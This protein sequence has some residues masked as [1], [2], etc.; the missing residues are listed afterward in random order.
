MCVVPHSGPELG[1]PILAKDDVFLNILASERHLL[2]PRGAAGPNPREG[3]RGK[4]KPFPE[5]KKEEVALK[6]TQP[7]GWWDIGGLRP[8]PVL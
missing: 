5:G 4:R 3:G 7:K 1:R 6:T 2:G 8:V